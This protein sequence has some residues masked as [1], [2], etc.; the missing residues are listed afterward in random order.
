MIVLQP[1]I[2]IGLMVLNIDLYCV[3]FNFI[4]RLI[5]LPYDYR[6]QIKTAL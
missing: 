3:F 6:E 5:T 1:T 2:Q 4:D